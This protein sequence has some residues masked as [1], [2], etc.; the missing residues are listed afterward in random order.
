METKGFTLDEV[1]PWGR[2]LAE[3]RAMFALGPAELESSILG[4]GD[5]P[6]SFNVELRRQGGQVVSVDPLYRFSTGQIRKRIK[7]TCGKILRQV[8]QNR[9]S[10]VWN[11]FQNPEELARQRLQTMNMFLADFA[12]APS[13]YLAGALPDLPLAADSFDLGLCSHF[14]LLYSDH[15]SFDFHLQSVQE[16]LRVAREVRI[17]PLVTLQGTVS[18]HLPSLVRALRQRGCTASVRKVSY[19]FQRGGNEMV[20]IRRRK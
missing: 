18:P 13:H 4:C 6:A 19:E 2:S 5:G 9:D 8:Q 3:Y 17:F 12:S 11:H 14:L 10:F 7:T 15:F 20:V 16:L 1:V